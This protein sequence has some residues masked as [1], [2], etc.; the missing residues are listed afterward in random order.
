MTGGSFV[1]THETMSGHALQAIFKLKSYANKFT[2]FLV[3]PMLGLF[4]KPICQ[5]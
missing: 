4:D 1:E 5:Y 3:L 2:E